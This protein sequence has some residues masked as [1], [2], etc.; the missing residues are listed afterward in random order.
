ME[1]W[2]TAKDDLRYS[3]AAVLFTS[4][5]NIPQF[6]SGSQAERLQIGTVKILYSHAA[7]GSGSQ[8]F[9]SWIS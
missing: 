4:F 7:A 2:V 8:A 5:S 9:I 1:L 3:R 6:V